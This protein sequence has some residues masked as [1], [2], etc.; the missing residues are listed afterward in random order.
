[1][2]TLLGPA[3][4]AA[5]R[6]ALLTFGTVLR[7]LYARAFPLYFSSAAFAVLARRLGDPGLGDDPWGPDAPGL[8]SPAL[9]WRNLWRRTDYLGG[10][11]GDPLADSAPASTDPAGR[12]QIDVELIDPLF[13]PVRGDTAMPA[14]GR[15]SN[16]PR[17]PE[18]QAQLMDL[19]RSSFAALNPA[20]AP[21]PPAPLPWDKAD[22][23][24]NPRESMG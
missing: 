4:G 22:E 11:V 23:L 18:F 8:V 19:V 10:K 17:D 1:M 3:R 7:R 20:T 13:L 16:F 21:A 14:A 2:A 5:N 24:M 12:V 15:H 6:T 9:R